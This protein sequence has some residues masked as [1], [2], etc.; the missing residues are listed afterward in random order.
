MFALRPRVQAP[1]KAQAQ[2]GQQQQAQQQQA[3]AKA[4]PRVQQAQQQQA[5]AQQAQ[6][7]INAGNRFS[8]NRLIHFKSTGGCRS[9]S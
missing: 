7:P 2:Q 5:Q 3:P 9:C 1:A 8:L 6:E 4:Q